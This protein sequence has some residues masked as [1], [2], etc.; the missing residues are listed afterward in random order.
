MT[1]T[2]TPRMTPG[3]C[4]P[5]ICPGRPIRLCQ[6]VLLDFPPSNTCA[7]CRAIVMPMPASMACTT[8]G[9]IARAA[10]ATRL[11]PNSTCRVPAATVIK[12]VMPQP[13]SETSPATMTVSP[14]AGPLTC[15]GEPPTLPT[16][17]PPTI[18]AIRPASTGAPE[19]IAIPSDRG[20]AT[21]KTT[22]EEG[23]SCRMMPRSRSARDAVGSRSPARSMSCIGHV[24]RWEFAGD[25]PISALLA[26]S[27]I[28][29]TGWRAADYI[30][31]T[32]RIA[33]GKSLTTWS[34][35]ILLANGGQADVSGP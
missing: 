9:E 2:R 11:S 33:P 26:A 8:T 22:S 15:S 10:R 1:I 18:A 27:Y 14:A 19:A 35:G 16:T 28:F 20:S 13:N 3:R 17:M 24:P 6:A 29:V 31:M 30:R 5:T 34:D 4:A 7:C 21:K 25:V 32:R 12:H 23:R